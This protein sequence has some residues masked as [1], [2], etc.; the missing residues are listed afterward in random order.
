[1]FRP[2]THRS[3]RIQLLLMMLLGLVLVSFTTGAYAQ[4]RTEVRV[5]VIVASN[6]GQGVGADLQ[7][8]SG[9][10]SAQFPNYDSFRSQGVHQLR[11]GPGDRQSFN[12]P[13]GGSVTISFVSQQGNRTTYDVAIPGGTAR[14]ELTPG[15]LIFVGGPRS[16]SGVVILMIRG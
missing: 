11:L 16:P 3:N 15:S 5:D 2:T 4:N 14:V 8:H 1:M 6:S 9:R 13:G 7:R 12:I 10:L